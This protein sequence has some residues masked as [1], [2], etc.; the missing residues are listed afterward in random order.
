MIIFF[1]YI[2]IDIFR[3]FNDENYSM[4][5]L[6][7]RYFI[8]VFS[9]NWIKIVKNIALIKLIK[10]FINFIVFNINNILINS[11]ISIFDVSLKLFIISLFS[12]SFNNYSLT[13]NFFANSLL[14]ITNDNN[15]LF[16]DLKIFFF[17]I[18]TLNNVIVFENL[19]TIVIF[20]SIFDVILTL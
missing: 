7:N 15:I 5:F 4:T 20:F 2:K 6:N 12:I 11:L 9:R 18:V 10:T 16:V 14:S 13:L 1:K 19:S 3:N 8:V 17:E